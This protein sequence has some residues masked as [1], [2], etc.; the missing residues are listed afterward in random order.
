MAS[1][2]FSGVYCGTC[3][4]MLTGGAIAAD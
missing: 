2:A 3:F 1:L 4:I